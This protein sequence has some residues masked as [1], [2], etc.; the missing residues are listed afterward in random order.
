M[1]ISIILIFKSIYSHFQSLVEFESVIVASTPYFEQIA[2][3]TYSLCAKTGSWVFGLQIP[4]LYATS[5]AVGGL[6][7]GHIRTS[8]RVLT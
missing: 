5:A 8:L 7:L 6:L 2:P 1:N 4:I 3:L